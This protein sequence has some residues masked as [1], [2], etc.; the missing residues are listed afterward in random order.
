MT[1]LTRTSADLDERRRRILYRCW[2]RGIR[3]MDLILGQFAEQ[4]IA[5]FDEA[6]LDALE[7]VMREE[8]QDLISWINGAK[9]VPEEVDTPMF[10]R[11]AATR[12]EFD[13]VTMESLGETK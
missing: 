9:P 4:N 8:D 12:P 6:E 13:P 7:H 1:G 5:G 3:E 2:H 10:R 11:I